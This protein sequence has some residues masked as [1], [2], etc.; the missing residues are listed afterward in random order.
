[1]RTVQSAGAAWFYGGGGGG[2]GVSLDDFRA[3]HATRVDELESTL[4]KSAYK[5]L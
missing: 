2:A 5:C 3:P 4:D 1:M